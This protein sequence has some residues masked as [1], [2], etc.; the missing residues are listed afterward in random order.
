MENEWDNDSVQRLM[1]QSR[2][3]LATAR[4]HVD[5]A[6]AVV[7]NA[8]LLM[9]RAERCVSLAISLEMPHEES[10]SILSDFRS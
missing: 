10:G 7:R 3:V 2:T 5:R 8:Q 6:R 1:E 4:L 9:Q